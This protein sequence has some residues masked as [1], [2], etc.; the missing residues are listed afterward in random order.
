[1]QRG[2][3]ARGI[4]GREKECKFRF[5]DM[6]RELRQYADDPANADIAQRLREEAD[7]VD[8]VELPPHFAA[9][10][11]PGFPTV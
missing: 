4:A 6:G 9:G 3:A 5:V 7:F 8:G 1:M 11:P 10:V 2:F